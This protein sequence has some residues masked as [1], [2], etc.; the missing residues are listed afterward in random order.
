MCSVCF[1]F[2]VW[3]EYI[4]S[5]RISFTTKIKLAMILHVHMLLKATIERSIL[6]F[7]LLKIYQSEFLYYK[8]CTLNSLQDR[9]VKAF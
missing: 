2:T 1:V 5:T 9:P 6:H 3:F 4:C 7:E 8:N